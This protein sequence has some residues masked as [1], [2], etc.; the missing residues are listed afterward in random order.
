[1]D[2]LK[3][4]SL[5]PLVDWRQN[6]SVTEVQNQG[7]SC[8]SSYTFATTGVLEAQYQR[9]TGKLIKFS[10]QNLLDCTSSAYNER[11]NNSGCGGGSVSES[12]KFVLDNNGIDTEQN[13][14]YQGTD[15]NSTCQLN[16]VQTNFTVKSINRI[17]PGLEWLLQTAIATIGPVAVHIDA[18][19]ETFQFYSSGIYYDFACIIIKPTETIMRLQL[20]M[21]RKISSGIILWRI[22]LANHGVKM[23]LFEWHVSRIITVELLQMPF[24]HCYR[25]SKATLT[26]LLIMQLKLWI[27]KQFPT[28]FFKYTYL[29]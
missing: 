22:H 16:A 5:P 3:T 26:L 17:T 29:L 18:S 8:R 23:V 1:M 6:G 4:I 25:F 19:L 14:P 28:F 9:Q 21:A 15:S 10:E 7:A 12:L 20:A 11:Y 27:N 2:Q 13:Y 24:I